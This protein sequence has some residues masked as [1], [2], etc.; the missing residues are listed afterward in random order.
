MKTII[1]LPISATLEHIKEEYDKQKEY[2]AYFKIGDCFLIGQRKYTYHK[3]GKVVKTRYFHI[4]WVSDH[5][6]YADIY[7]T[8]KEQKDGSFNETIYPAYNNWVRKQQ[9]IKK[10]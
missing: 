7:K 6:D 10:L 2:T 1:Q 5:S 4:A 3:G 9:Q 8:Y